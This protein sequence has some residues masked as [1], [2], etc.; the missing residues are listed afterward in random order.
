VPVASKY[1][2]WLKYFSRF[3]PVEQ[4]TKRIRFPGLNIAAGVTFSID[5][6]FKYGVSCS[7]GEGSNILVPKRT[8]LTLG[9]ACYVGRYV[10]IGPLDHIR[11]GNQTSIQDRCTVLGDVTLGRY[12]LISRNVF[13]ASGKHYF[14][15]QPALLILDQDTQARQSDELSGCHSRPI[16]IEDDCWLGINTV[17]MPGVTVGKGSILGA[18]SVVVRDVQPYT[19]VAGAPA[20][21]IRKRLNF[22]PPRHIKYSSIGDLPYFYSG[23]DISRTER[24]G[25]SNC[26]G[27]VAR[28]GFILCLDTS[29]ARYV[30]L[31]VRCVSQ[32]KCDLI[33]GDQRMTVTD[34]LREIAFESVGH[35]GPAS[36][37][38]LRCDPESVAVAV[39]EAWIE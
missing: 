31:I 24:N 7:I 16:V 15:L 4:A 20:R 2:R 11:I 14:D 27:I 9:E 25:N 23:F 32:S 29:A 12:C 8:K 28:G 39:S 36:R 26:G 13:I 18:N 37:I 21:E 22:S 38:K 6:D 33:M 10:E 30:H 34:E 19:V 3:G 5:G 35:C 17:I 1:H